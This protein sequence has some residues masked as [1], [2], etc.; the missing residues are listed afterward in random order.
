MILKMTISKQYP[1]LDARGF[2]RVIRTAFRRAL[3]AEGVTVPCRVDVLITDDEGIRQINLSQR[4]I[5]RPTD[6]LSFQMQ[7]L[8]PGAFDPDMTEADPETGLLLLGSMAVS[9]DRIREQAERFGHSDTHEL[10]YLSVHSCLHLL[11]YDH[12]DEG[13]EKARMRGR[14]KEIMARIGL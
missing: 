2:R 7:Q 13:P 11:G 6:V 10:A 12:L 8:T 1:E 3:E 4:G 9:A 5:D 14:E